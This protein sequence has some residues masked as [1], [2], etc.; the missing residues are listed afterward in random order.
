VKGVG[1]TDQVTDQEKELY[2][3]IINRFYT[4][5][6]SRASNS[7]EGLKYDLATAVVIIIALVF[8][9]LP[10]IVVV[11]FKPQYLPGILIMVA[12][13]MVVAAVSLR[14][15]QN[16]ASMIDQKVKDLEKGKKSSIRFMKKTARRNFQQSK[17]LLNLI[18]PLL[19][20]YDAKNK[21]SNTGDREKW[22]M[23]DIKELNKDKAFKNWA[24]LQDLKEILRSKKVNK[25][26]P[27]Q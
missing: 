26:E 18:N 25:P 9:I 5:L 24:L 13:L 4:Y 12:I 10:F 8:M 7:R 15:R 16:N 3:G 2:E 21:G 11:F 6:G 1:M 20:A 23:D 27:R 22:V 19:D 14:V 17:R